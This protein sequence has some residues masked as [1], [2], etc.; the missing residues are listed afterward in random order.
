MRRSVDQ[1]T[2]KRSADSLRQPGFGEF[3]AEEEGNADELMSKD[4]GP[5][6]IG[7]FVRIGDDQARGRAMNFVVALV[8]QK[9]EERD[10]GFL[11]KCVLTMLR[12]ST[13]SAFLSVRAAFAELVEQ[14]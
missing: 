8:R 12:L 7:A 5:D 3:R 2:I 6:Q 9:I 14:V 13:E 11:S 10:E 4:L 1:L